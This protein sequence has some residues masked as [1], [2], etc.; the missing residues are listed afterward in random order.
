MIF[1]AT[2]HAGTLS[3]NEIYTFIKS[4]DANSRLGVI[5]GLVILTFLFCAAR[6]K[7]LHELKAKHVQ[8]RQDNCVYIYF[9]DRKNHRMFLVVCK[10][11]VF[12]GFW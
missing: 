8:I 5:K 9:E 4:L 11:L 12:I 10:S 7:E 3:R 2:K 6:V 1:S